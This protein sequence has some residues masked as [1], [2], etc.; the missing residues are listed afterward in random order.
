MSVEEREFVWANFARSTLAE[1]VSADATELRI[2]ALDASLF[3]SPDYDEVFSV[4]L[5]SEDLES[6]EVVYCIGRVG[7]LL[8][9][10]RG[11][12]GTTPRAFAA[13]ALVV[14]QATAGFFEQVFANPIPQIASLS[15][16]AVLEGGGPFT[17]TITGTGFVHD[18]VVR[19]NGEDRETTFV[20]ATTLQITVDAED[21]ESTGLAAITVFNPP[22]GGGESEP[23]MLPIMT[24]EAFTTSG[25]FNVPPGV[26]FVDVLVVAGGGAGGST[27]FG[28]GGGGGGVVFV[29]NYA[30]TPGASIPVVVGLGGSDDNGGDS[31]FGDIVAIG[32]GQG[33]TTGDAISGGSGG[34]GGTDTISAGAGAA[35]TLGQGHEGGNALAGGV[36]GSGGGGGGGAGG[37]GENGKSGAGGNGGIGVD[38][39]PYFGV[40]YGDDGWFGGGGGGGLGQSLGGKGGG[41]SGGIGND[42]ENRGMPNTGGGGGGGLVFNVGGS[43]IVLVRYVLP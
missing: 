19:W 4:V 42:P 6:F 36:P 26:T 32:G 10:E 9:V 30:V 41:G 3:P 12:E 24:L 16:S 43:G 22:L 7:D 37:P 25:T 39:S 33:G 2:R 35:G 14:H 21:V 5:W 13:G 40:D 23:A 34:G 29:Q 18:S 28:G 1:G 17:L 31:S 8:T 38:M 15:P 27:T 20:N 11:K